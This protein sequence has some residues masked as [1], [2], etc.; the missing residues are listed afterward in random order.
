MV[1]ENLSGTVPV[2][3]LRRV[4]ASAFCEPILLEDDGKLTT[5]R[6]AIAYSASDSQIRLGTSEAE[7]GAMISARRNHLRPRSLRPRAEKQ[8]VRSARRS[9]GRP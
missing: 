8:L 1:P 4:M 6:D 5:L 2:A 9:C 3:E 7:K